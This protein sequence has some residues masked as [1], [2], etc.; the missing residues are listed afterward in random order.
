MS[1]ISSSQILIL[2]S[3]LQTSRHYCIFTLYPQIYSFIYCFIY[4]FFNIY[5]TQSVNQTGRKPVRSNRD[6]RCCFLSLSFSVRNDGSRVNQCLEIAASQQESF[7]LDSGLFFP[8]F[9]IFLLSGSSFR[10]SAACRSI[11]SH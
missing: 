7:S 11:H 4:L 2:S 8:F 9:V 3:V 6:S 10:N 1:L 5:L